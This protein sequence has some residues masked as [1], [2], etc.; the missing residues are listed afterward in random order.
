MEYFITRIFSKTLSAE[1]LTF[2]VNNMLQHLQ[3]QRLILQYR[4]SC[5]YSQKAH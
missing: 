1:L 3:T 4:L 5:T 2:K